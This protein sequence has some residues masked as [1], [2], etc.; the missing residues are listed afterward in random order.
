MY[1]LQTYLLGCFFC[2]VLFCFSG[3]GAGG[4]SQRKII[5]QIDASSSS[6]DVE[7]LQLA[8]EGGSFINSIV[9]PYQVEPDCRCGRTKHDVG[10]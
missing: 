8:G 6:S 9:Q 7:S 1:F 4:V 2:F 5:P 10:R 3:G